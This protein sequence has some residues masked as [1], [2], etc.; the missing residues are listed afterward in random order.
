LGFNHKNATIIRSVLLLFDWFC[1]WNQILLSRNPTVYHRKVNKKIKHWN[2]VING[3]KGFFN[4][5][6]FMLS[7]TNISQHK[8]SFNH[9]KATFIRLENPIVYH[10]KV[11]KNVLKLK[12]WNVFIIGF[13][14]V[15]LFWFYAL[16]CQYFRAQN[17][18][19]PH[20]H[21]CI[22]QTLLSKVTYIA[23]KVYTFLSGLA[24]NEN[25][26]TC[27]YSIWI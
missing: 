7:A 22:W 4:F 18:F 13:L 15:Q 21:S 1:F 23:F 17:H 6:Y 9:K 5:Y 14:K 2:V 11:N 10:R 16:S 3:F 20:L 8:T 25:W 24:F 26:M 12:H 19:Y 27:C